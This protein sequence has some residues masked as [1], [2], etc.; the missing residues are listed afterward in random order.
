MK[1]ARKT[2]KA[3]AFVR[4][5]AKNVQTQNRALKRP[6]IAGQEGKVMEKPAWLTLKLE[7]EN[8]ELREAAGMT[9]EE[10]RK[11][12]MEEKSKEFVEKGAE[13]YAKAWFTT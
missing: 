11:C 5:A 13:V 4:R 3:P 10:A 8:L 7:T 6:L 2:A 1:H 9:E 12:G